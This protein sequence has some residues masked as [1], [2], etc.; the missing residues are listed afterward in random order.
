MYMYMYIYIKIH[1]LCINI[2]NY[3]S[4]EQRPCSP[5]IVPEAA[6]RR[7]LG[8]EEVVDSEGAWEGGLNPLGAMRPDPLEGRVYGVGVGVGERQRGFE[9]A[10]E[11]GASR[12]G[13]RRLLANDTTEEPT[14]TTPDPEETSDQNGT[15]STPGPTTTGAPTTTGEG[16]KL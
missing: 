10:W 3:A 5:P 6:S 2:S 11:G 7:L 4:R 9:G 1:I 15:T 13:A 8:V 16:P 12:A 14:T